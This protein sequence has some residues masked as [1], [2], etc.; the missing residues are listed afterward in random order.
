ME[1]RTFKEI[2]AQLEGAFNKRF[3]DEQQ[4]LWV[5]RYAKWPLEKF[6]R[7]VDLAIDQCDKFPTIAAF[8]AIGASVHGLDQK[9]AVGSR[10][11]MCD[12]YPN[13]PKGV[14]TALKDGYRTC[15]RCH[16]CTNWAGRYSERIPVWSNACLKAGYALEDTREDRNFKRV[17]LKKISDLVRSIEVEKD[18]KNKEWDRKRSLHDDEYRELFGGM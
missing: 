13:E 17:D 3:T 9:T 10:C 8:N 15:F 18:E 12:S 11:E 14:V 16:C 5:S 1:N 6:A 4:R 7:V 2:L